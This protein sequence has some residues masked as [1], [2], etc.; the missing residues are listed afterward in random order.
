MKLN[1]VFE[2]K[3]GAYTP[4]K[5][6]RLQ[7]ELNPKIWTDFEI[8]KNVKKQLKTIAQDFYSENDIDTKIKDIIICGSLCN[9]NWSEKY[10]DFDLHIIIDFRDVDE[11]YDLVEN[12]CDLAKKVWNSQH[13]IRIKGYD[14]EVAI[15]DREIMLEEIEDG[16]MGG[17]YSLTNDNWIKKPEKKVFKPNERLIKE[18]SKSIMTLIDEIEL[19][20]K[21]QDFN[22]L[23]SR[24]KRT[25]KKI[26]DYRKSGLESES[27]EFSIGNLVF[28]LLRRNGYIDRFMQLRRELYDKQF[29]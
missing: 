1:R 19:D 25:W 5:S 20:S 4:I 24:I 28:K 8:D 6:F 17:V 16:K 29:K 12:L 9:Y 23:E 7:D 13:R 10:S 11:D 18:K 15:Q 14:V 2:L 27:G 21:E 26:K 22:Q 3:R